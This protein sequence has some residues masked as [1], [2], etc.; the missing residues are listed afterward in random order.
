MATTSFNPTVKH[1]TAY[2]EHV[3]DSKDRINITFAK[4]TNAKYV[5]TRRH[6]TSLDWQLSMAQ[7]L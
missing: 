6:P 1:E 2:L 5:L 4:N 3:E 7:D